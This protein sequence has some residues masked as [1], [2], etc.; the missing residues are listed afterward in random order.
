MPRRK[1]EFYCDKS[2][3]GCGKYFDVKLNVNLD[4]NY[5]VH[6]P[7]CGHVHYR[8]VRKGEITDTRFD[9]RSDH[10]LLYEDLKPMK[11][12]CRDFQKETALETLGNESGEAFMRRLWLDRFERA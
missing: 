1:I 7:N 10:V 8:L 6:C 9:N 11:A 5:R 4:G 3:G 2:G 12:S